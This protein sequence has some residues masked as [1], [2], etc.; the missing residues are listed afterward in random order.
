MPR[1]R[2]QLEA[3]FQGDLIK[4]LYRDFPVAQILKNDEQY[5]QGIPDLTILFTTG[6]WAVLE[7]KADEQ[8]PYQPN[9]EYFLDLL[10]Q[11]S[12]SATIYPENEEV[13]LRELQQALSARRPARVSQR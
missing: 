1:T 4:R 12:F 10:G 3:D 13:V 8:S 2:K 6:M 7:C 5:Q 11:Y 9:Q